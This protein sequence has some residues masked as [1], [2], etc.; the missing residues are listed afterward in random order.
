MNLK[1]YISGVMAFGLLCSSAANAQAIKKVDV[2]ELL[3]VQGKVSIE[4]LDGTQYPAQKGAILV[5]GSKMVVFD[6][7]QATAKYLQNKCEVV[8]KKNRVVNIRQDKQCSA[9]VAVINANQYA[10]FGNG[11]NPGC[12]VVKTVTVPGVV[13]P[14]VTVAPVA[15]TGGLSTTGLLAGTNNLP[16]LLAGLAV[17]GGG[18]AIA[19][20]D[21]DDMTEVPMSPPN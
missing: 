7:A 10:K 18:I 2:V 5:H 20:N 1:N 16:Y 19:N 15:T 14:P 3:D 21:D 4:R 9:G 6:G 12:C 8:Y 13:T 11:A 17:V